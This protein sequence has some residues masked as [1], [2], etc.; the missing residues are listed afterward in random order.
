MP[1]FLVTYH[2]S[3]MPHEPE[4]MAQAR[5]AF[6][7]WAAKAGAP[8]V[9]PGAP[10]RSA[11][12]LSSAGVRDEVA[13]GPINGWSVVEASDADAAAELLR[14]HPFI[15]RGGVLQIAEPVE[16]PSPE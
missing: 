7:K 11:R 15:G 1:R 12:S 5:E 2:G 16:A 9:E 8:L 4:A 3:D 10:V 6:M 14:D 13:A